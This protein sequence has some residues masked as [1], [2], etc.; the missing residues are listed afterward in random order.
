ML[1]PV[2]GLVV[3]GS[4]ARGDF[5]SNEVIARRSPIRRGSHAQ[6]AFG[7]DAEYSRDHWLVRGEL[8]WSRWNMPLVAPPAVV[9]LDALGAWV[10]GRYRVHPRVVLAGAARSS[11]LLANRGR[12]RR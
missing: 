12:A 11:R 1:R 4:A 7:A 8:V 10:E 6:T 3:G 5:L 9:D 2:A